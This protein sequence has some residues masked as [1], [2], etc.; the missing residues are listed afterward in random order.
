MC[1]QDFTG[2]HRCVHPTLLGF[3]GT[4][5]VS[6]GAPVHRFSTTRNRFTGLETGLWTKPRFTGLRASE[7]C[8]RKELLRLSE[9]WRVLAA[10]RSLG[11]VAVT[12]WS[13]TRNGGP[14]PMSCT[15]FS[16]GHVPFSKVTLE[17]PGIYGA[18]K[19]WLMDT[20]RFGAIS[21][22][23]GICGAGIVCHPISVRR[24]RD[25]QRTKNQLW[26]LI[27]LHRPKKIGQETHPIGIHLPFE[28]VIGGTV[29]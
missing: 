15:C 4:V 8:E 22:T 7:P 3:G 25:T 12:T 24:S 5:S 28:K 9:C 16:W 18:T 21:W 2:T 10:S 20:L 19:E 1:L 14:G 6:S 27:T 13:R 11:Q 29:M 26:P 23:P 17:T